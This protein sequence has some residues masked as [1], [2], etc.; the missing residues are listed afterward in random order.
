MLYTVAIHAD[1]NAVHAIAYSVPCDCISPDYP[2]L[3]LFAGAAAAI[4]MHGTLA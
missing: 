4:D 1:I 3:Q 2:E